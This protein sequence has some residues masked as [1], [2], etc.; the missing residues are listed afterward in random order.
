MWQ[1]DDQSQHNDEL[2]ESSGIHDLYTANSGIGKTLHWVCDHFTRERRIKVKLYP[3]ASLSAKMVPTTWKIGFSWGGTK[4]MSFHWHWKNSYFMLRNLVLLLKPKPGALAEAFE[5]SALTSKYTSHKPIIH[6]NLN[7]QKR[8]ML[9]RLNL[10]MTFTVTPCWH[11]NGIC[12]T[13]DSYNALPKRIYKTSFLSED[14]LE[15]H[16]TK[17]DCVTSVSPVSNH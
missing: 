16:H 2:G 15:K 7:T 9:S 13:E 11:F 3:L 5:L 8:S 14:Q 10:L 4:I 12:S 17:N 1:Q 6:K